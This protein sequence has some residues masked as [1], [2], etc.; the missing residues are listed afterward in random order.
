[1]YLGISPSASFN[2]LEGFWGLRHIEKTPVDLYRMDSSR[3]FG[4][5]F[6]GPILVNGLAY[7]AQFGNNNGQNSETDKYK[8]YRFEGR[9]DLNPGFA[10]EA[11]YG[12][13]QQ[14]QGRDQKMYQVF[15]GFR[16]SIFRAGLQYV[17][18]DIK[19]GTSA[20]KTK[21][22]VTSAFGVFDVIPKKATVYARA[23]WVSGNN[24][25]ATNSGVPRVDGIDYL[26]IDN[27][28]DFTFYVF[29]M[30]WYFHPNFRL[31]PNVE[32]VNYG[33]GPPVNGTDIKNDVVWRAT[34]Y[35]TF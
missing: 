17:G 13:F 31:G 19:S 1:M 26:P 6:E 35:W 14:P 34:F 5:S 18:K 32:V 33:D 7:V 30:E 25:L 22:D 24:S 3:D 9:F 28:H 20:P 21:I 23:D 15:G 16:T 10:F 12:D 27:R 2:W 8:A 11:F 4:V 29:G